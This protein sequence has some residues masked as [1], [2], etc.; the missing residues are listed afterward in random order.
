MTKTVSEWLDSDVYPVLFAKADHD[1][2]EFGFRR[3]HNGWISTTTIKADGSKGSQ[4]GK[5]Y[6]YE[7]AKHCLKDYRLDKPVSLWRYIAAREGLNDNREIVQFFSRLS[8]V[9]LPDRPAIAPE[10]LK[11]S[12]HPA[13]LKSAQ[14]YMQG[15]LQWAE[16]AEP[17]RKYLRSRGY[18]T[19]DIQAMQLGFLPNQECLKAHLLAEGHSP[20][21]VKYF[22]RKLLAAKQKDSTPPIGAS[23]QLMLPCF[24]ES[25][26]LEG[27]TFR[28]LQPD[29]SDKYLNM[30]GLKKSLSLLDFPRGTQDLTVV[31][32]VFDAKL[33]KARGFEAVVPLNGTHLATKQVKDITGKGVRQ[34]T[35]CLD[36]DEP[37]Q[38][39]TFH[40][41]RRLCQ[42]CSDV[43]LFVA[44]LPDDFNDAD[45]LIST[46]GIE[47]F[48]DVIDTAVNAGQY[49]ADV[50]K[51]RLETYELD[52]VNPKERDQWFEF[53]SGFAA[54]LKHPQDLH[55][56]VNSM[57]EV[58]PAMAY[59]QLSMAER[60]RELQSIG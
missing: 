18:S 25:Q 50:F 17:T 60:A 14:Q 32:G 51:K 3:L 19:D 10:K 57:S 38:K 28:A 9:P 42:H 45:E 58:L 46:L 22:A 2:P 36:N 39:A 30:V 35:L 15:C 41:A 56:Y 16:E 40:I 8:G 37:G 29:R 43:R 13:V 23:H 33:A 47:T 6:F 34:I 48:R 4:R 7:N 31:E 53:C 24:G 12:V 49:F 26:R 20:A 52:A 27:F 54:I 1:F 44:K 21:C 59:I 55:D 11:N 5:V